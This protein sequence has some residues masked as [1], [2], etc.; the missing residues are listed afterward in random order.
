MSAS[1]ALPPLNDS[2]LWLF[3]KTQFLTKPR[4]PP[5]STSLAGKTAII[6]GSSSGIG[7][8]AGEQMLARGLSR[9][10]MA[11][12]STARGE[13]A[14]KP[15]RERY[16]GAARIDVWELDQAS[17]ESVRAFAARC[18]AAAQQQQ[19]PR[20]DVVV[21]NAGLG[22]PRY[23]LGGHG[24][25]TTL[26]VNYLGAALLALLLL[27]VLRDS[28]ERHGSGPGRMTFVSS[29][30]AFTTAFPDAERDPLLPS[31]SESAGWSVAVGHARYSLTKLLALFLV[32]K[33]GELVSPDCVVVNAVD[34][35][36]VSSTNLSGNMPWWVG[37]LSRF[38]GFFAARTKEQG[39]WIYLDAVAVKGKE[40]H[41]G[42]DVNWEIYP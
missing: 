39:A 10:I 24:W 3:V 6:T 17:Y 29:T 21:L 14:A 34:P 18:A 22:M 2:A 8:E 19:L 40:S 36:M 38:F 16:R 15:L 4:P 9:L 26:Q 5:P 32:R 12:R 20:L 13:A 1:L 25:E 42:F 27:P 37:L 7:L 35:S 11:V 31:L 23:E 41:G 30:N 33:L 28:G